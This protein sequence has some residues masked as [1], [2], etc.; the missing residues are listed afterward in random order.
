MPNKMKGFS[1]GKSLIFCPKKHLWCSLSLI[2]ASHHQVLHFVVSLRRFLMAYCTVHRLLIVYI[3]QPTALERDQ[4]RMR[5]LLKLFL[6]FTVKVYF[7][8]DA[9]RVLIWTLDKGWNL[10]VQK[11]SVN[12]HCALKWTVLRNDRIISRTVD[13][14]PWGPPFWI[15]HDLFYSRKITIFRMWKFEKRHFGQLITEF[16]IDRIYKFIC[17]R[18][19]WKRRR[20]KCW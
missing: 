8:V 16:G 11:N 19:C 6:N 15:G 17:S 13:I 3:D 7:K 18:N 14:D 20:H 9:T 10:T 12:G 1:F 5:S 2:S 4:Y